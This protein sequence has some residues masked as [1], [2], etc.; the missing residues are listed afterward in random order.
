MEIEG[1][2]G[3]PL[4]TSMCQKLLIYILMFP[5]GQE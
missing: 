4:L 5:F 3:L 1:R 2:I